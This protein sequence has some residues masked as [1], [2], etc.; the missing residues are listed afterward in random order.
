MES[1]ERAHVAINKSSK[2][3]K[4]SENKK[5]RLKQILFGYKAND[6]KLIQRSELQNDDEE[7]TS[8]S[9]YS[10]LN[11]TNSSYEDENAALIINKDSTSTFDG[12]YIIPNSNFEEKIYEDSTSECSESYKSSEV[13]YES[14]R[15]DDSY[16]NES[17][18]D[19]SCFSDELISEGNSNMDSD[20]EAKDCIDETVLESGTDTETS[21]VMSSLNLSE[22]DISEFDSDR[23]LA[24]KIQ[25]HMQLRNNRQKHK[26][27]YTI[28]LD[29]NDVA[30]DS[31]TK[32]RSNNIRAANM[33][34]LNETESS[35]QIKKNKQNHKDKHT[36]NNVVKG[37]ITKEKCSTVQV[38]VLPMTKE[39]STRLRNN[40]QNHTDKYTILLD[41]NEPPKGPITKERCSIIQAEK[42]LQMNKEESTRIKKNKQNH[43]DKY[44]IL[45]DAEQEYKQGHN[46]MMTLDDI[47]PL[48]PVSIEINEDDTSMN[49]DE[50]NDDELN[51]DSIMSPPYISITASDMS[52]QKLDDIIGEYKHSTIKNLPSETSAVFSTNNSGFF[53]EEDMNIDVQ[54]EDDVS[55]LI[56][57]L[58][59]IPDLE[60]I[61]EEI[62]NLDTTAE[63]ISRTMN[64]STIEPKTKITEPEQWTDYDQV[65][66]NFKVYYG[67]KCCIVTLK[68][69]S[70]L[71]IQGKV[72]IRTLGGT[73]ELFGYTLNKKNCNI[74]APYYNFAQGIKTVEN[75]ND[76]YGLFSKLTAAGLSVSEAEDIVTTMGENDGV[77]LLQKLECRVMDFIENNFRV[78]NMF[79]WNKTIEP[80]FS[81]TSDILN[82]SLFSSRP[83]KSFDEHPSWKE[84]NELAM[85]KQSR[86]VVC[87]GKGAGKSTYVRYQVNK[88]LA[89]GPVLVVDL[90]PG[91]SLFTVAGNVSATVVTAPLF[92]PSFTHLRKPELMLSIGMINTMD[93][94]K[95]YASAVQT[96]ITYCQNNKAFT[97]MPWIVNTMGMTN[98]L[99]LKFITLI[100][101]LLQPT[102]VLQYESELQNQRFP[103]L[104]TPTSTKDLFEDYKNDRLFENVT[105]PE[106]LDYSFVV[107]H[108]SD[109][110]HVS[111]SKTFTLRPKDERYLSFLAYFGLLLLSGRRESL[112]GITPYE[113]SLK[114]L[115]IATNVIIKKEHITKVL[116]G[117]LVALC[118]QS[119]ET[120]CD[121]GVFTLT[122]KP[123]PCRGHGLIRG[124]D[125]DKEVLY[126]ITP[127]P[128]GELGAVDT[129]LYAD[130]MP[131]L[132][133]HERGLPEGTALPYRTSTGEQHKELMSTPRRRYTNPLQLLKMARGAAPN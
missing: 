31:M 73:I 94:T 129:L 29:E 126:V 23:Q 46:N 19:K 63:S 22:S 49:S 11:L 104:L 32:E 100:I 40:K 118:Q 95:R 39:E 7:S 47:N 124:I 50:L 128:G 64:N 41:S 78:T 59:D 117:K 108:E 43:K 96:L 24:A 75:L 132:V 105:F 17:N 84:A 90:D 130:W 101:T 66:E 4:L 109:S 9:G 86:G 52:T 45:L 8:V 74:Y 48:G 76:Y 26:D 99:G 36:E 2:S 3:S 92:G 33:L 85:I 13:S 121:S 68:H 30:K 34:S 115:R 58:D 112:L 102:Y 60:E 55:S 1:F 28:L 12:K 67:T 103:T 27:K 83:Y 80:Y 21:I 56:P 57:E 107:A 119:G 127:V 25:E 38:K 16:D 93:N 116:N 131:D 18:E 125:W 6:N 5:K 122:D 72:K 113:V 71:F 87:G 114:D 77:I 88:L 35:K 69:P 37:P 79:K 133:W 10:D 82:C 51:E 14:A 70:K 97:D 110:P 44:T 61:D 106:D 89:N 54:I 91:Q 65:A 53:V 120:R 20:F 81:K 123:L 15:S 62:V 111:K 42:L 98:S